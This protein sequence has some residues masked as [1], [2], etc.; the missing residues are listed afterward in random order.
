MTVLPI[1]IQL[2]VDT[3]TEIR[4]LYLC[5]DLYQDFCRDSSATTWLF[6]LF[7]RRANTP[8]GDE[9]QTQIANSSQDTV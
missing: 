8:K 1:L 4:L 5:Q 6:T 3:T 7:L 9:R 2:G